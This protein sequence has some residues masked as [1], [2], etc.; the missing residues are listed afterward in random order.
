[1]GHASPLGVLSVITGG[2]KWVEITV[3]VD[4]LYLILVTAEKKV[5]RCVQSGEPPH[6][7]NVEPPRPR[8]AVVQIVD[9]N[10]S[11]AWAESTDYSGHPAG[12]SSS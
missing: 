6:L 8:L 7:I 12:V 4:P 1:M 9:M 10:A 3:P 5:W 2:G 11:N